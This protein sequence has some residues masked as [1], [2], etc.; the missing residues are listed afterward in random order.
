[1]TAHRSRGGAPRAEDG[2]GGK[3]VGGAGVHASRMIL[4][5]IRANGSKAARIL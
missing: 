4:A 2:L 3:R 5:A 1:M